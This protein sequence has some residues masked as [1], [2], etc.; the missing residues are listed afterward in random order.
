MSSAL[1]LEDQDFIEVEMVDID[2]IIPVFH[3]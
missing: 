3:V 1:L 2:V